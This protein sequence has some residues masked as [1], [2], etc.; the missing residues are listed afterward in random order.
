MGVVEAPGRPDAEKSRA[1]SMAEEATAKCRTQAIGEI[2][3]AARSETL[4]LAFPAISP[5]EDKAEYKA[6]LTVSGRY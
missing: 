1:D 5:A 3:R 4:N 2:V 6:G